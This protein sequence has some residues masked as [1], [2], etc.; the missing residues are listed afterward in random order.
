MVDGF[1]RTTGQ[2]SKVWGG[3][4]QFHFAFHEVLREG[5]PPMGIRFPEVIGRHNIRSPKGGSLGFPAEE[6]RSTLKCNIESPLDLVALI[7]N[8]FML[9]IGAWI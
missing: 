2:S 1:R 3:A 5:R 9:S 6:R 8:V 4:A 7:V